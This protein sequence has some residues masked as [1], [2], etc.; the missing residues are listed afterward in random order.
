MDLQGGAWRAPSAAALP[1]GV[2]LDDRQ[3]D[4]LGR[5]LLV[6]ER[7]AGLDR[8]ADLAVQAPRWFWWC[9]PPCE[10]PRAARGTE[11][12]SPRRLATLGRWLGSAAPIR[13]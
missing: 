3:V 2:S 1:L 13:R 4:Q 12:R 7:A 11:S 6:G 8:L 9:R 5:G 10:G